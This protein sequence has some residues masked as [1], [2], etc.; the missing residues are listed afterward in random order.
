MPSRDPPVSPL[1][2]RI[3]EPPIPQV[4]KAPGDRYSPSSVVKLGVCFSLGRGYEE[5]TAIPIA[6]LN[7]I[8]TSTPAG[9]NAAATTGVYSAAVRHSC[10]VR[11]LRARRVNRLR[12]GDAEAPRATNPEGRVGRATGT[13]KVA[14]SSTWGPNA[15][16]VLR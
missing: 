1:T 7:E 14:G 10:M 12:G 11:E 8:S 4:A 3:A 5:A 2:G 9:H 13:P 16:A 15:T 6:M